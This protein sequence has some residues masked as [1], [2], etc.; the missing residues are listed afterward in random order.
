MSLSPPGKYNAFDAQHIGVASPSRH[1]EF[2][3]WILKTGLKAWPFVPGQQWRIISESSNGV[4]RNKHVLASWWH[5]RNRKI[6][7]L[8]PSVHPNFL[9][10]LGEMASFWPSI[11][12]GTRGS[13]T[14]VRH[15]ESCHF[16]LFGGEKGKRKPLCNL[17]LNN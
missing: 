12:F 1:Y 17:K 16:W 11:W 3:F 4:N 13:A 14:Y 7:A 9:D 8:D 15:A 5:C 10:D 2:G 6:K